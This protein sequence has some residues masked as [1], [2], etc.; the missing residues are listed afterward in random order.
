M[1]DK[2]EN[3]WRPVSLTAEG[4]TSQVVLSKI[5][6]TEYDQSRTDYVRN[7]FDIYVF[8]NY[9]SITLG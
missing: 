6:E 3:F 4:G 2:H 8:F 7:Q 9:S 5:N 1:N